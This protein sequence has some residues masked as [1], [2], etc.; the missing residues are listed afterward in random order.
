TLV[1]G[2]GHPLATRKRVKLDEVVRETLILF[3][4]GSVSRKPIDEHLAEAGLAP[5]RV[6]EMSSPEAMRKLVESGVGVS[7]LPRMT[8]SES[9]KAGTLVE[10]SVV[11]VRMGRQIGL[12]WRKGRYF[13]PA[14]QAFLNLMADAFGQ[15]DEWVFKQKEGGQS[16]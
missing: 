8:V 13:S 4:E 5:G 6:M 11:G 9:V 7:F 10:L 14:I 12:A 15:T 1:V 16:F 2:S 3:H